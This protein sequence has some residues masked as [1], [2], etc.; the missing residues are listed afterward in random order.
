ME[1]L[2]SKKKKKN[3][4]GIN[5]RK[6]CSPLFPYALYVYLR[7]KIKIEFDEIIFSRDH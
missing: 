3:T 1:Y 5:D 7:I 2:S 6:L 4:I